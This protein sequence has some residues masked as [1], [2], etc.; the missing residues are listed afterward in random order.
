SR[1][2]SSDVCSSDLF[3][4]KKMSERSELF[5]QRKTIPHP[6]KPARQG[7]GIS[8]RGQT[9]KLN[10]L[11]PSQFLQEPGNGSRNVR[12]RLRRNAGI[13]NVSAQVHRDRKSVV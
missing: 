6:G 10:P 8:T 12:L 7:W 5:F 1:D 11:T 4:R 2:W 13:G 3:C 9:P